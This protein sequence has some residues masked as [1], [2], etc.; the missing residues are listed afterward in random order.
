MKTVIL[1]AVAAAAF[2]VSAPAFAQDAAPFTGPHA[3]VLAGYDKLDTNSNGLG[4]PDGFLYGIG[5]GYDYQS[6]NAVFGIE[7]EISD[8]T[9]SRTISGTDIDAARDLYI[10]AR[11]G[12]VVSPQALAY[13]KAGYTNARIETEGF[14]GE[15][16]DGVRVGAGLEYKLGGQVFVKGEYRYSNYEGDVERHQVVGGLG[17]RF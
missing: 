16:G 12:F 15:N 2:A 9:A 13:V 4:S 8:S 10:G 3:E 14:G 6:G 17:I 11:A 5:L 7:G 1:A